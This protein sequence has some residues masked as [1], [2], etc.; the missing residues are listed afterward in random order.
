[1]MGE[2]YHRRA[3]RMILAPPR[4]ETVTTTDRA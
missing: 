4:N 2:R 3:D 1:M